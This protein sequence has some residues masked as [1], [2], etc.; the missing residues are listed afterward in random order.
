LI[1]TRKT[2]V[3]ITIIKHHNILLCHLL[4]LLAHLPNGIALEELAH[5]LPSDSNQAASALRKTGLA[6]DESGRLRVLA[7][8]REYVLRK[9][10]PTEE[11]LKR[12]VGYYANATV[13]E[14]SKVGRE[15][16]RVPL[17]E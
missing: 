5:I 7:P 13:A 1:S 6:F 16:G 4:G 17:R 12:L 15:G 2:I 9:H 8:L 10:P 11:D 3:A 14:G